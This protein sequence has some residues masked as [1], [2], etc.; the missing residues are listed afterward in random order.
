MTYTGN[1]FLN[2]DK[3]FVKETDVVPYVEKAV[4]ILKDNLE[5]VLCHFPLCI[6]KKKYWKFVKDR[7][8]DKKE[9][10]F[11]SQCKNCKIKRDC[12]MI[13]RTYLNKA[14]TDEFNPILND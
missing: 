7:T 14:G 11:T 8:K 1:A 12:P 3:V 4:K 5:V 10:H 6:I 13:L 2:K 9:S